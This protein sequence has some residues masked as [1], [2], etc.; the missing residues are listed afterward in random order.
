MRESAIWAL[1]AAARHGDEA[2]AAVAAS[3]EAKACKTDEALRLAE[4]AQRNSLALE[5]IRHKEPAADNSIKWSARRTL[6]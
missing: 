4:A 5:H 2:V 3:L 6:P 1:G